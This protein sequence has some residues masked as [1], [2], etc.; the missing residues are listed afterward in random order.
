M[1]FRHPFATLPDARMMTFA[2]GLLA[3]MTVPATAEGAMQTFDCTATQTC[4]AAGL[5]QP[6]TTATRF[7]LTPEATG[8]DGDGQ[9][10]LSRD[11]VV[12]QMTT[13]SGIGPFVWS[14]GRHDRQTLLVTG[15]ATLLL[16]ALD[17]ATGASSLT[18][19]TC[20]VT[21]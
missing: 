12:A 11:G 7:T 6:D 10:T 8:T 5:C 19:L 16:H 17:L 2:A 9:Y 15:E 13:L 4:D 21:R 3:L 20:D 14:E 1:E 18:F